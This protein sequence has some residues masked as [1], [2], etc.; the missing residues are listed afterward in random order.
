[1]FEAFIVVVKIA[2]AIVIIFRCVEIVL[3]IKS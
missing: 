1:M 2:V 3:Q